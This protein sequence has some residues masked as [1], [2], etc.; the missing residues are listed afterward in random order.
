[1]GF[2]LAAG[3]EWRYP[4][5]TSHVRAGLTCCQMHHHKR[6]R[7]C[8]CSMCQLNLTLLANV[9]FDIVKQPTQVTVC[10]IASYKSACEV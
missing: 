5:Q 2:V 6:F 4:E 3:C 9:L 10:K 7:S 8:L 1:M